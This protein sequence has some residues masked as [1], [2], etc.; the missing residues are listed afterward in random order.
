LLNL[1][2]T[3]ASYVFNSEAG[4]GLI[5]A[6]VNVLPFIDKFP[7][8]TDLYAM[9]TTNPDEI[10]ALRK[11]MQNNTDSGNNDTSISEKDNEV[12]DEDYF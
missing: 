1:S 7:K 6:G 11:N 2:E 5:R 4:Q 9:M 3:Q 8:D 10:K 12:D